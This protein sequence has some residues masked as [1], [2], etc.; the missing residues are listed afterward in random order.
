M[1]KGE[2]LKVA[3][4]QSGPA[5]ENKERNVQHHLRLVD[6][7]AR[8]EPDIILMVEVFATKYFCSVIDVSYF[9][10]AETIPGPTTDR[11]GKKARE[12]GIHIICPIF[13]KGRVKGE[14]FDSAAI[15]GPDG[16][17]VPGALP[18]GRIVQCYS[19]THIPQ[20]PV[21]GSNEKV[22]FRPGP[23][24]ATFDLAKVKT[25]VLICYD[26]SFPEAW[27][28][29]M[30][31][32]AELILI[33][34]TSWGP[35]EE[36][37]VTELKALASLNLVYVASANR[38][39]KEVVAGNEKTFFGNSCIIDPY[40]N[41]VVQAPARKGPVIIDGEIDLSMVTKRRREMPFLRDR[42]PDVYS[43]LVDPLK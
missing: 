25:G 29:L 41:V 20:S 43:S 19:K 10:L 39:G 34:N 1:S 32:G 6:Q 36:Q 13:E 3:I 42:R 24:F 17:I 33:P 30:L 2:K 35:R 37:F 31:Q 5:N 8:K 11:F 9:D 28:V 15:L 7:A 21:M 26:R 40:G 16:A 18:G 14:F 4:I 12:Y 23:G 22:Y 38:A 27:R